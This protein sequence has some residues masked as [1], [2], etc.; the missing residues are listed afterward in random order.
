MGIIALAS[1]QIGPGAPA[2]S[3]LSPP[4]P[5]P[6]PTSAGSNITADGVIM[7]TPSWQPLLLVTILQLIFKNRCMHSSSS[8]LASSSVITRR[9]SAELKRRPSSFSS[10]DRCLS[11]LPGL[12][13]LL[14]FHL[15]MLKADVVSKIR[16][17]YY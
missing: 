13:L 7:I 12:A 16:L 15:K 17:F 1:S 6:P 10:A 8:C 3:D 2:L 14:L 4:L 5:L 11:A 9:P